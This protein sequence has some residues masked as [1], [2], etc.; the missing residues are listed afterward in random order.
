MKNLAYLLI[1]ASMTT[2]CAKFK[3]LE[4]LDTASIAQPPQ[5]TAV[6]IQGYKPQAGQ[7]LVNFFVSNFSVVVHNTQLEYST[8]RDGLYDGLK[9][10][11]IP[12]YGFSVLTPESTTVGFADLVLY[13]LGIDLNQQSQL[14]CPPN[15]MLSTSNDAIIY[16]D[17]R[18]SGSPAEFL[19]L[20][21]CEKSYL[22]LNP[23]TPDFDGDGIPDYLELRCGLNPADPNDAKVSAS[24]DGVSNLEK[25]KDHIPVGE[26]YQANQLYAYQ[27]TKLAN[28][29]GSDDFSV[30]NIPVLNGGQDN[31]LAFYMLEQNLT[32]KAESIYTAYATL[33]AG[34][35]GQTLKFNYWATSPANFYNQEVNVP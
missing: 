3:S 29:D 15:D 30:T 32:T 11:L 22:G 25:C 19:G 12:N 24:G 20:R 18:L 10:Q 33:K 27:Y 8:A 16:N 31:F 7:V 26:S 23:A 1:V 13:D 4:Q 9:T 21:D 35:A 2:G 5:T 17:S 6:Y 34:Y 14:Y 28:P